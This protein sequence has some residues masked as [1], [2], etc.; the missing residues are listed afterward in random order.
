MS[1]VHTH[2]C[3]DT[4]SAWHGPLGYDGVRGTDHRGSLA[5]ARLPGRVVLAAGARR[6]VGLLGHAALAAGSGAGDA[7]VGAWSA[8]GA[9]SRSAGS[10]HTGTCGG[11]WV[12]WRWPLDSKHRCTGYRGAWHTALVQGGARM[13]AKKAN[14]GRRKHERRKNIKEKGI[15]VFRSLLC[16]MRS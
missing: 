9:G 16:T 12:V 3:E 13:F 5:W 2:E 10:K 11:R 4:H 14:E 7:S 6:R 15:M 8:G 1:L